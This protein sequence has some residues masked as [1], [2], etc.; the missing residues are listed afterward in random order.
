MTEV[1]ESRYLAGLVVIGFPHNW[2]SE[3]VVERRLAIVPCTDQASSSNFEIVPSEL[4]PRVAKPI[5]HACGE[6]SKLRSLTLVIA[7]RRT[8]M[9]DESEDFFAASRY[10]VMV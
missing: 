2:K 4:F 10:A 8:V 9:P 7:L 5:H 3:A 1:T 6:T